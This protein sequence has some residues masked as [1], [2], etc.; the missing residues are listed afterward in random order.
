M[1]LNLKQIKSASQCFRRPRD[2]IPE[3]RDQKACIAE[4]VMQKCYLRAMET[5]F[6]P[7]WRTVLGWVDRE[8]FSTVDINDTERWKEGKICSEQV[9]NFMNRWY[10][11]VLIPE[12]VVAYSGLTLS[13]NVSQTIVESIIPIIKVKETPVIFSVSSVV[14]SSWQL[15]NDIE[16]RGQ[17]WLVAEALGADAV[18]FERLTMGPRGGTEPTVI[19][20]RKEGHV[21][22]RKMIADIARAI[23]QGVDYPVVSDWCSDC[24]IRRRCI[25]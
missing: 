14:Q 10:K 9:L 17:M 13:A 22:T 15:Y 4:R 5:D 19:W 7:D 23:G 24:V 1:R 3:D 8:V 20:I 18:C 11:D 12:Q 6:K 16:V 2:N 25:I 21:R